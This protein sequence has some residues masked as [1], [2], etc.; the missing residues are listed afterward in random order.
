MFTEL[1]IKKFDS[2]IF[3][4][5]V[6]KEKKIFELNNDI[7]NNW[8]KNQIEN[9]NNYKLYNKSPFI[10]D[11]DEQY[12]FVFNHKKK[13]ENIHYDELIPEINYWLESYPKAKT[14]FEFAVKYYLS[15][16]DI[17]GCL[18]NARL[19]L[20]L[21]LKQLLKNEKSL[22]NQLSNLSSFQKDKGIAAEITSMFVKI[23][24]YYSKYQNKNVK[25]NIDINVDY[26]VDF[27]FG[28]TLV[29]IRMLIKPVQKN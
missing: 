2:K 20:E 27:I 5:L 11:D 21:L 4:L 9:L 24:D 13:K 18:D 22:E 23:I 10:F 3:K 26:E 17:R 25:H 8:K 14:S 12:D 6:D 1:F 28:I 16:E 15:R 19:T 7:Y 29:F